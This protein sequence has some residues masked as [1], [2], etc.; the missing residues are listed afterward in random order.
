MCF[1]I[2]FTLV[3]FT[4]I[5]LIPSAKQEMRCAENAFGIMAARWRILQRSFN[6]LPEYAD[7]VVKSCC[8]LHNYLLAHKEHSAVYADQDNNMGNPV[9]GGWRRETPDSARES[10]FSLETTHARNF[11]DDADFARKMCMYYFCNPVG[12]VSWQWDQPGMAKRV[13]RNNLQKLWVHINLM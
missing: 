13:A 7:Y 2:P 4:L 11:G 3:V 5:T 9:A 12:E 10:L 1:I 8:V 6:L